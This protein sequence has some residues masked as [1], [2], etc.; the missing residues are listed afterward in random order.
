MSGFHLSSAIAQVMRHM[1]CR[2]LI[3]LQLKFYCASLENFFKSKIGPSRF[4]AA[5]FTRTFIRR[6]IGGMTQLESLNAPPFFD[7]IP[8]SRFRRR[9]VIFHWRS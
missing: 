9:I 6:R 5:V 7:F 4:S 8:P 1:P 3:A 2:I